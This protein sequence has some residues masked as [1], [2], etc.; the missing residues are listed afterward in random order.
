MSWKLVGAALKAQRTWSNLSPA[1]KEQV[2]IAAAKA[3]KNAYAR[4]QEPASGEPVQPGA[5]AP[6]PPTPLQADAP[7]QPKVEQSQAEPGPS[8][9][10]RAA[11]GQKKS[12]AQAAAATVASLTRE[13]GPK[14]AQQ[15][16]SAA[17]TRTSKRAAQLA[18]LW[19]RAQ[20]PSAS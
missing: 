2:R 8:A 4:M 6:P 20:K 17:A 13:H 19:R 12:T 15:A 10:A 18:A 16:A 5:T 3:A 14:L 7:T 1:Q 11:A 9:G